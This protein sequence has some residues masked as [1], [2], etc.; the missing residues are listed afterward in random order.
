MFTAFWQ[1]SVLRVFVV[2]CGAGAMALPS[3]AAVTILATT[4]PG[5]TGYFLGTPALGW[6]QTGTYTNVSVV[7]VVDPGGDGIHDNTAS[8]TVYLT[9]QVG[10]GTTVANELAHAPYSATGQAFH[11][12]PVTVFTDLTLG[13]GTYYLVFHSQSEGGWSVGYTPATAPGVA[14]LGT[15][16]LDSSAAS[17]PPAST[18][19][20]PS[21]R[22]LPLLSV[23]GDAASPPLIT[24]L[25]PA[26][27]AAGSAGFTL[28]VN[29]LGFAAD[30][31][32]QW[33]GTA[34]S[35]TFVSSTQLTAAVPA[36]L[37]ASTGAAT[38]TVI[39]GGVTTPVAS[40][41]VTPPG[42]ACTF[43][44][45]PAGADFGAAPSE[46][47]VLVTGSTSNCTATATTNAPWISFVGNPA[48][49]GSG[50]LI[51]TLGQ[52]NAATSR[53]GTITIGGQV[54]TVTQG[55]TT[56]TYSLPSA[57]QA[58]GPPAA[59]VRQG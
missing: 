19:A 46:G 2:T 38:I 23:T 47:S 39:T 41:T 30:A 16:P 24:S 33:N 9:T 56:C 8:G 31:A 57:S 54:F 59:A 14:L 17:Y 51:Y 7:V 3:R 13:P 11:P 44:V 55:G 53:S 1:G 20:S 40:F 49:T 25:S 12:V 4:T 26:T 34:L 22:N 29:G 42:Q 32:A 48:V 15:L 45:S 50:F 28:T 36:S 10:P 35:T 52:N 27:A 37:L 21:L 43:S 5:I 18:F 6:S 58:F